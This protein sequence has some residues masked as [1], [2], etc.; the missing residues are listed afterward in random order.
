MYEKNLSEDFRLRLSKDD[1]DY[2]KALSSKRSI[3]VSELVRS[4]ISEYRRADETMKLISGAL[5]LA[6][7]Q[8]EG[9]LSHGDT[10]TD[11]DD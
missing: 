9:E 1:M 4:I 6:N 7:K 2:L 10:E 11:I 8:K 3:N 5:E